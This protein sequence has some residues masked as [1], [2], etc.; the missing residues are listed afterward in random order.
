MTRRVAV[1][2]QATGLRVRVPAHKPLLFGLLD[3]GVPLAYECMQGHC[4]TC[5]VTLTRGTVRQT[6]PCH[7]WGRGACAVPEPIRRQADGAPILLCTAYPAS[8]Y[9]SL[10]LHP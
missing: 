2:W 8:A 5:R 1:H 3:A 6:P 4:R 9:L 10:A 7:T